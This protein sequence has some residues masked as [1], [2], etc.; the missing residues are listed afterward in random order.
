MEMGPTA[1]TRQAPSTQGLTPSC[2]AGEIAWPQGLRGAGRPLRVLA[3]VLRGSWRSG[4]HK[5]TQGRGS[6]G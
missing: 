4:E 6:G 1:E 5:Q 3:K 2:V